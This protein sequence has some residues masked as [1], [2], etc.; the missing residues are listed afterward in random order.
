MSKKKCTEHV[1]LHLDGESSC[2]LCK[3][4]KTELY[5]Q[6]PMEIGDWVKMLNKFEKSHADC[7]SGGE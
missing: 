5:Y 7:V 6:L 2:L 1:V 3:N 4:C